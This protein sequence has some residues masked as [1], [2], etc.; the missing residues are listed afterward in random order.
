MSPVDLT[1][2]IWPGEAV[3]VGQGTGEPR[4]LTEALVEQRAD[5]HGVS[6]FLGASYAG[7]FTPRHADHLRFVGL[8]G[9]GANAALHRAGLLDVLPC[10][11][12]DLPAAIECGRVRVDVVLL[13]L[14]PE[15]PDGRYS[16]GVVADYL[17]PAIAK[18]RV[19]IAEVNERMPRTLGSFVDRSQLSHV[20]HTSRPLLEVEPPELGAVEQQIGR[21]VAS[22]IPPQ[23][24]LQL[25]IGKLG[26]TVAHAL[27]DRH[28][29]ALHGGVVGDWLVDLAVAGAIDN[30][31]KPIDTGVTVTGTVVG[32]QRLYDFVNENPTVELREI[33]YTH[34]AATLRQLPRLIATNAALQVD[35]TGQVNAE[36]IAGR[37]VGAVGGQVDFVRGAMASPGGRSIIALPSTA[38]HGSS[39]IVPRLDDGVIT[40]SRADA[41]TVVTEHGIAELR[42]I[43]V[44]ERAR[45]LIAVADPRHREKL[46]EWIA[47][48]SLA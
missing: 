29:I 25:G 37:H 21:H 47:E 39:R 44:R 30:T 1:Q 40:T 13:Q 48:G 31:H 19:V 6:V 15:G 18:A 46:E 12:S 9:L 32:T 38:R 7:T 17:Q 2:L 26:Y 45:R 3:L 27:Q 36:T 4:T 35:L 24:V 10:H 28:D 43:T 42:G 33:R 34:A 11:V 8:G 41:D 16:L 22:L 23:P 14:S 20:V 5:L